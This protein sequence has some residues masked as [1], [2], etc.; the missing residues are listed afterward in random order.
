METEQNLLKKGKEAQQVVQPDEPVVF[1]QLKPK[2]EVNDFDMGEELG[3]NIEDLINETKKDSELFVYQL[4]G[5]SDQIY[6]EAF[7]EVLHF[8][9]LMKIVLTNRTNRT[10]PNVQV[11]LLTQG[12]LKIVDKPQPQTLRAFASIEL[13]SAFKVTQTDKGAIYGCMT[14]DSA[15]GNIPNIININEVQIDFLNE[16]EQTDCSEIDFKQKWMEFPWENKVMVT[17]SYTVLKDY[18]KEFAK[19]INAKILTK[20]EEDQHLQNLPES[21]FM[22]ANLC[23][24]SRFNEMCLINMSIEK[25]QEGKITGHI[26]LRTNTEGMAD[27]KSVV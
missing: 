10:L 21:N 25:N 3:G 27:R 19:S 16:L 18:I 9:I 2:A 15:S 6:A 13:K 5:Y 11:E 14:Y 8:D 7:L 1:R 17:T 12:N 20:L 23:T 22:V 26:K 24:K 4:T